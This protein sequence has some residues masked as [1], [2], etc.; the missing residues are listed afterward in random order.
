MVVLPSAGWAIESPPERALVLSPCPWHRARRALPMRATL[1]LRALAP[2]LVLACAGG[3]MPG[4]RVGDTGGDDGN[5]GGEAG[6]P[7][8]GGSGG[9]PAPG[10]AAPATGGAAGEPAPSADAAPLDGAPDTGGG[11][12]DAGGTTTTFS[13]ACLRAHPLPAEG[14][15][16][17]QVGVETRR[18]ILRLPSG[19]DGKKPW[20]V[21]FVFHGAGQSA[22]YFDG[23]TDLRAQTEE[24][25]VLVFPDGPV[26]PDGRRSWVFRSADNVIFVDALLAWLKKNLCIDPSH[27]FATGLSSGG[28]MSVTLACQRGDVFKAVATC[29]GGMV[30][31]ENCKGNP[32]VW[33]RL[34][35]ADSA[36]TIASVT[37]ARDFWIQRNGCQPTNPK[38]IE[39]APCVS[40]GGCQGGASVVFCADTGG[41]GWPGYLS[42]AIWG[43]FSRP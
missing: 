35:K 37:E 41:H 24:K 33:L 25:A 39:P 16:D 38:P 6:A 1:M 28:Y 18:F 15:H 9:S 21:I 42:K 43:E 17:L 2:V 8:V 12:G 29:S 5:P 7:P 30:E 27:L 31:K 36:G 10:D 13:E 32:T 40:Y 4:K 19:Y 26:K 20:P 22:G 34:G 11:S 23:N 14:F 3:G